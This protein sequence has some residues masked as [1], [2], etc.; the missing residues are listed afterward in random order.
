MKKVQ[1]LLSA[2]NGEDYIA[3]QIKSILRQSYPH[4]SILVRD[5]GSSDRTREQLQPFIESH[6]DRI[7][8]I[9]GS[10]IGV[11]PSFFELVMHSDP[12]ADYYCFCDQ[13]DVWL[14]HKIERAVNM[15]DSQS[16]NIPAMVFTATKLVDK[17][18]HS[19]GT[20]P[21]APS[22][23]PSF[24]NALIQNIA[25]GATITIN[26]AARDLFVNRYRVDP[27]RII[28]HDWWFYL[29]VSAF[30]NVIYDQSPSMLYRQHG[31]NVVGGSNSFFDKLNQK[32]RSY[33]KHKGEHLLVSQAREFYR[34]YGHLLDDEKREQLELFIAPRQRFREKIHFLQR[35]KLYRQSILEQSLFRFLILA[36][37]I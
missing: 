19:L 20:W 10:N 12:Q 36:G 25:V 21:K 5:D 26:R 23:Q 28:M 11:V 8:Q 3:E 16:D 32:Y 33:L 37:Y 27:S 1:V 7:Q 18:L 30:G 35:S 9:K 34:V 14:D 6:P 13:D 17:E 15:L 29:L 2:Y 31:N 4:I 22:K 24:Y